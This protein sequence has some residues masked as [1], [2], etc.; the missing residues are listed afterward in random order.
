VLPG[1]GY[2]TAVTPDGRWL[3]VVMAHISKVGIVDLQTMKIAHVLDAPKTPQEVLIRPDG[4]FAY[5]SCSASQQ[6]AVFDLKK[7]TV[8][9]PIAAG[10]GADGLA[11]AAATK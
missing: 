10:K 9:K 4:T 1:V 3:V 5:V 11:W 8:E 7:F 6:V 2:G